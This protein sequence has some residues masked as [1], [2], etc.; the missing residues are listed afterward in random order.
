MMTNQKDA[1]LKK[2]VSPGKSPLK[3]M[4]KEKETSKI[5]PKSQKKHAHEEAQEVCFLLS[6]SPNQQ[7]L[8]E[9]PSLMSP[10]PAPAEPPPFIP[11]T[12]LTIKVTIKLNPLTE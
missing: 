11:H 10:S 5:A 3:E 12:P 4:N 1:N 8:S 2:A 9:S 7:T 6:L